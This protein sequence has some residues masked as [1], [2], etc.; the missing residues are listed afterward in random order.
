[1]TAT[2]LIFSIQ[3]FAVH[4]GPGIR[5]G[6]FFK[7]CPL[8]CWWCHSP[9]SQSTKPELMLKADRCLACGACYDACPNEAVFTTPTGYDTNRDRCAGC[10][11]CADACPTGARAIAGREFTVPELMREID[12]D[13]VFIDR[14]HGG[15]TFSGG[16]PL[17]QWVFLGEAIDACRA[18]G[19]HTAVET[20]GFGTRH[21]LAIAAR[22]DLVFFDLK[23]FNEDRH[24]WYTG[25]SNRIILDNFAALAANHADVRVRVPVVPGVN[26]DDENL[27]DIATFAATHGVKTI[28]RLP[29]HTAGAAKYARLGRRYRLDGLSAR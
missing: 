16:E 17:M 3:R 10:G 6:V 22:A 25:V 19:L 29:Y 15:V 13:R 28:E 14:S 4:D 23:L 1:M 18:A 7:G 8:R 26:D 12:K 24:R 11:T 5:V 21:A 9:E 20:S 2:G 27:S